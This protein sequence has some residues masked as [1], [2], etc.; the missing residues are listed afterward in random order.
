MKKQDPATPVTAFP[1]DDEETTF[2]RDQS[3]SIRL[4]YPQV[5]P[6]HGKIYFEDRKVSGCAVQM[7]ERATDGLQA[8]LVVLGASGLF[9]DGCKV[10]PTAAGTSSQHSPRTIPLTNNTEI[11]IQSKR[12]KFTYPPKELRA[13]LLATPAST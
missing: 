4:Y 7:K 13:A 8:F 9:V 6:I 3:C 5:S 12:F 11:E 2:G 1:L 10:L